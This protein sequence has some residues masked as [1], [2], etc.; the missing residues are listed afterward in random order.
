[1]IVVK[2]ETTQQ[3]QKI[4]NQLEPSTQTVRLSFDDNLPFLNYDC[5]IF[6]ARFL[7]NSSLIT[8]PHC[9]YKPS[10]CISSSST[11]LTNLP[12]NPNR[13][14]SLVMKKMN[15][16]EYGPRGHIFSHVGPFY[17]RAVSNLDPQRYMHRPVQVAH[18]L[19]IE[20]SYTTKNMA[21]CENSK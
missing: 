15:S 9:L 7:S 20:G 5:N 8:K 2:Y 4:Q 1:M 17:E 18:S 11:L 16:S 21:T 10:F 3:Q 19:F 6:V 12:N 14:N 13:V